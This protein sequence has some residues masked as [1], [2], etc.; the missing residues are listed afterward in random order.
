MLLQPTKGRKVHPDADLDLEERQAVVNDALNTEQQDA[1]DMLS[2]MRARF[3]ACAPA[4]FYLSSLLV[5]LCML[6]SIG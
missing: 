5:C 3:D 2:R 1:E 4:P 6:T